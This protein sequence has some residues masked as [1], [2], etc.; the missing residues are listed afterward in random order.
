MAW[1]HFNLARILM[2]DSRGLYRVLVHA[3]CWSLYLLEVV[4]KCQEGTLSSLREL[5]AARQ[6]SLAI[7]INIAFWVAHT[8]VRFP[9]R[10]TSLKLVPL[11]QSSPNRHGMYLFCLL[12][13]S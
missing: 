13:M 4:H 3:I 2:C 10:R 12:D 5:Q 8:V 6:T 11:T 1:E 9:H 7:T